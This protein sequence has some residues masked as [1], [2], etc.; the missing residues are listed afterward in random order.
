MNAIRLGV[1]FQN[2]LDAQYFHVYL[3]EAAE[4]I[5]G[6]FSNSLWE[7]LI[8]QTSETE[9][10]IRHAVIAI[11]ALEK[12][13]R[14]QYQPRPMGVSYPADDYQ[15]ALKQ[16][17][18]S[19]RCMRH[20]IA[21][22]K[23]DLQKALIASLLV[24]C[25]ESMLGNQAAAA[26]HAERG[27]MLLRP[28]KVG[29]QSYGKKSRIENVSR[30]HIS[31]G[32]LLETFDS[33]D[34]QVLLFIDNRNYEVRQRTIV[35]LNLMI[36]AMPLKFE[37][38]KEARRFWQLIFNRNCHFSQSIKSMGVKGI[39][40][41][42]QEQGWEGSANFSKGEILFSTEAGGPSPLKKEQ[43]RYQNDIARWISAS[44]PVFRQIGNGTNEQE[45]ARAALLQ[46]H[47]SVSRVMLAGSFIQSEMEYDVY[48]PEYTTIITNCDA[49]LRYNFSCDQWS[50]PRF[51]FD[52]GIVP[53]LFLVGS[54]CRFDVLREKAIAMLFSAN[55]REGI[56]DSLAVAHIA[57]WLRS[58]EL[59][60]LTEGE[61]IPEEKRAFLSAISLDLFQRK[62]MV[63]ASQGL[64]SSLLERTSLVT[65]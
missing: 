22:G 30:E 59:G 2:E 9:P 64:K 35:G 57:R 28:W 53:A 31:E 6:L 61:M 17:D 50:A 56:W 62:V 43:L 20:A 41:E 14:S 15:Y 45:K 32:D 51:H 33:L 36:E 48:R 34:L 63:I 42:M 7:R 54:R 37:T 1:G 3:G 19:L 38:L 52:I 26:L 18:I 39:Q 13:R 29:N 12:Q 23:Q 47:N 4:Q 55:I 24:F 49:V 58:I 21:C 5:S 11:G 46:V 10:F 65:W 27:L 60:D 44:N 25:V 40:K 8:P 16:Y